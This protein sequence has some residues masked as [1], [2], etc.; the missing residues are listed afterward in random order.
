MKRYLHW[1]YREF[2]NKKGIVQLFLINILFLIVVLRF[3]YKTL[4]WKKIKPRGIE[5]HINKTDLFKN[6]GHIF[7]EQTNFAELR[8]RPKRWKKWIHFS[9]WYCFGFTGLQRF[10]GVCFLFI[11]HIIWE[12]M[13]ILRI[14]AS[15]LGIYWLN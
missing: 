6:S 12:S 9:H 3:S 5:I 14:S 13:L 11:P 2:R 1:L 10:S 4:L 15:S 7:W 8:R